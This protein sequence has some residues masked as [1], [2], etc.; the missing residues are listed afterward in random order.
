MTR[1]GRLI[2]ELPVFPLP[3]VVFFP[4]TLLPLHVFEPRYR[5]LVADAMATDR[6]FAIAMLREGWE[7][8]YYGAPA[9]H[10]T[11]GVGEVV[12]HDVLA[13]GRSNLVLR[14]VARGR[15]VSEPR[16][17]RPYRVL[18]VFV[19]DPVPDPDPVGLARTLLA[20]RQVFAALVARVPENVLDRASPLFD[21]G[22]DAAAVLD[23]IASAS[24]LP[25]TSKQDLLA[26]TSPSA[27]A[28]MLL[29]MLTDY[30]DGKVGVSTLPGD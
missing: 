24:P 4:S 13:D 17:E 22:A 1:G 6:R 18:D 3:N 28:E 26:A 7:A 29:R 9:I 8:D 19:A 15:I 10:G 11:V 30:L 23:V 25:P 20:V 16:T 21:P 5:A 27:R 14:G 12:H 2:T